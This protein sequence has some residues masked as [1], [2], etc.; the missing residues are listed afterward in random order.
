VDRLAIRQQH[1]PHVPILHLSTIPSQWLP[2]AV[3]PD[4]AVL[5]VLIPRIALLDRP[6]YR[7]LEFFEGYIIGVSDG[8]KLFV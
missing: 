8:L 1:H 2:Q 7:F 6:E 5:A 4:P 3:N